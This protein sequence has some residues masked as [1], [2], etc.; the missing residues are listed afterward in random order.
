MSQ[1]QR[2]GSAADLDLSLADL[3][4]LFDVFLTSQGYGLLVEETPDYQ[5]VNL[6]KVCVACSG[7]GRYDSDGAPPCGACGGAGLVEI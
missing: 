6:A 5:S 1:Y 7:S 3:A 4:N 2:K